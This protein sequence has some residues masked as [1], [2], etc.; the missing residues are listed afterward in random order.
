M[1]I[2]FFFIIQLEFYCSLPLRITSRLWGGLANL[3]LPVSFRS[4]VYSYYSKI[5]KANLD[6]IDA[7]L[8]EF[9]SLAEFFVRPLK[10]NARVIA[11]DANIVN[12][13]TIII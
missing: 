5:F 4:P 2:Y 11:A 7:S 13:Y 12:F 1:L 9:S 6:E 8:T 10:P 3:E